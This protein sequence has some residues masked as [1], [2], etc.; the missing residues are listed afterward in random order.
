MTEHPDQA[1]AQPVPPSVWRNPWHFLA[2][3]F[4]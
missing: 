2:F 3:G 4:G 1:P